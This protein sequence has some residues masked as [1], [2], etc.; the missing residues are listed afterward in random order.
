MLGRRLLGWLAR[1]HGTC[2]IAH[3][4]SGARSIPLWRRGS[5]LNPAIDFVQAPFGMPEYDGGER[6]DLRVSA[7]KRRPAF[8]PRTHLTLGARANCSRSLSRWRLCSLRSAACSWLG[9]CKKT[10]AVSYSQVCAE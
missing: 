2:M 7:R 4:R 5:T 9:L 3:S 1:A 10:H 8:A 6:F